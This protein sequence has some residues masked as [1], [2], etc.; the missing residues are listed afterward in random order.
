VRLIPSVM[1]CH[2]KSTL[3]QECANLAKIPSLVLDNG[4]PIGYNIEHG[5]R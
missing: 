2:A 5:R 4:G 3:S 1:T